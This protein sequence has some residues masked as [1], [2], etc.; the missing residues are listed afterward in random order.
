MGTCR[1]CHSREPFI[2]D[3][4]GFCARCIREL[5]EE[6]RPE[7]QKV[8][9]AT[10]ERYGLAPEPP[11]SSGGSQCLLCL[12]A[13]RIGEGQ[14]GYCGLRRRE[15]GRITGGRPHEGNLSYYHDPLP[16]NCVADFICPGGTG[17]GYPDFAHRP[18]P[19]RGYTNLAVFYR[20][21]NF[22]CLFC[23]NYHFKLT[24]GSSERIT[25]SELAGTVNERTGCIC[26]FG[27]DPTPHLLHALKT[28]RLARKKTQGRILR[29][30]WETNGAMN[31]KHLGSMFELSLTSGGCIKFDLKAWHESIHYTLCGANNRQTLTN[32]RTLAGWSRQRRNPP[33]LTASTLL[34]PGY[35]DQSEVRETARFIASL[36]PEIPYSL[37]AFYPA[38]VLN[39]LPVTSRAQAE[40]CRQAALEAGLQTVHLGNA[41]LLR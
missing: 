21:C 12:H 29:I 15:G 41:Q 31:P 25:A 1:H 40:R 8:H 38:F 34:I 2:S 17:C 20:A 23:Q 16:T 3:R 24:T 35:V 6:I 18:G 13:C 10:R 5:F 27:G 19:E 32:F 28:A 30:C 14:A 4:I 22:N 9:W 36:D 7:I 33:L 26:F 37:L 11:R 39:D